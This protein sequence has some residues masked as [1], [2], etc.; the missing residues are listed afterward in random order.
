MSAMFRNHLKTAFRNLWKQKGFTLLNTVGLAIGVGACLLILQYVNFEWSYENFHKNADNIYRVALEQYQNGEAAF[1]SA[2]NYPG[3][4]PA[5]LEEIPEVKSVAR[6]YNL[7]A[8]NNMVV[9]YEGA[10]TGPV[11]F[12]QKRLLYA[13]SSFLPMFSFEM[14]AGTP[15]TALA[16][17]F[18]MVITE[19]YAKRYFGEENPLGKMLHLQDDDFNDELCEVTGVVKDIPE[20]SHLKFDILVSYSTLFGR[21]EG[22]PARYD[23][24]WRRKDM[25]TYIET[26]DGVNPDAIEAKLPELIAKNNPQLKDQNREDIMRL[27]P[28]K[29]IH[30]YSQ[31]SDEPEVNGDG[32]A[33][34]FLLIIAIFILVIAYVNYINLATSRSLER[35]NEV[36]VRKVMGAMRGQLIRQFL[37][38]SALINLVA[39][40]LAVVIVSF[41]LPFFNQLTGVGID[42]SFFHL[43]QQSWFWA[44]LLGLFV[45]GAFLSGLYPAFVLSSFKPVS[46]L[47]G[48]FR[49]GRGGSLFRK[50]LVVFQFATCVALIVG[51]FT[52]Y[53]QLNYMRSQNL[54]FNPKQLLVIERPGVRI[55]DVNQ[56]RSAVDG[57]KTQVK[58]DPNVLNVS[59]TVT[60]PGKKLRWKTTVRK[61]NDPVEDVH[62]VNVT[63]GDFDFVETLEM[64]VIAGRNFSR[65]MGTDLDTAGLISAS[66]VPLLGF[67]SPEE[68]IGK[69]ITLDQFQS[70]GIIVG[71]VNDYHQESLKEE[72]EP[73]VFY[74][75]EYGGEYYLAKVNTNHLNQTISK[76]ES[77]WETH[78]PGNPF[79]YFFLDDLFDQ[80]YQAD[81]RFGQIFGL[82]AFLAIIVGCLGLF[83]LAAFAAQKRVKEI[84]IRKVLGA[85]VMNILVLL[86][87]DF[88]KLVLLAN[89]IAWPIIVL[90]MNNWLEGFAHRI[91]L[92]WGMFLAAALVV[93]FIALITVS[94]QTVRAALANPVESIKYE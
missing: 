9:T 55:R 79:N 87:K 62:I 83:G 59:S 48:K 69:T 7:G 45:A 20:N 19:S 94:F 63:G 24:S 35:A 57:F 5:M 90:V 84:G 66:L 25:Y 92:G 67:A 81:Q 13:D 34:S 31:L 70:N 52:V 23:Q 75:T 32:R 91:Q 4:A 38:E 43:A 71:V 74:P 40:I 36:G 17:P 28:L 2:E 12:K 78:F 68:A 41:S 86:S 8:K 82:F 89:L 3:L 15:E 29:D 46:V 18:K 22:A 39:L 64:D 88:V 26:T 44:T 37:I 27:Q 14:I 10:P 49:A 1:K 61:Y 50:A 21:F 30:L 47:S 60:I 85:S 93:L 56:R 76:I 53:R 51:T 11:K 33:V 80:Q 6:M 73:T 77:A 65:E 16:E 58:Q 54:G 42:A 72:A